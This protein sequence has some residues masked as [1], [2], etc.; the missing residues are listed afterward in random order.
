MEKGFSGYPSVSVDSESGLKEGLEY[1]IHK[2]HC[3]K[4]CMIGGSEHDAES[5]VRRN[6][7]QAVLQENGIA[8]EERYF[9]ECPFS[10]QGQEAFETL[11]NRN[12]DMHAVFCFH[13]RI[14]LAFYETLQKRGLSAGRDVKVLGY[15][16]LSQSIEV[17]PQ[18]STVGYDM[19]D[20][21]SKSLK[22]LLKLIRKEPADSLV[23]PTKLIARA[24]TTGNSLLA[25]D[26][27]LKSLKLTD[28]DILFD[29]IFY[30]YQ[31]QENE[32]NFKRCFFEIMKHMVSALENKYIDDSDY[33]E[34]C[35]LVEIF[36]SNGALKYT[37]IE[38]FLIYIRKLKDNVN[39]ICEG[40]RYRIQNAGTL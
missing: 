9:V 8:F 11:L 20:M 12:P 26:F 7:Y 13:D 38:F 35:R 30:K 5:I 14:A 25:K 4:I 21:C 31:C 22:L 18:L 28:F 40:F 19:N 23:I 27:S 39:R 36:F 32:I 2:E 16:N 15:G 17:Q 10:Q 1:L 29:E 33:E 34:L 37:D 3:T 24:S 6:I